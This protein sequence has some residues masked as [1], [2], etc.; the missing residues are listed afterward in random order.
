[1]GSGNGRLPSIVLVTGGLD[2][3]GA[4]RVLSDM[5]NYWA[6][7]SWRTTLVTWSGPELRDFYVLHSGVHRVWLHAQARGAFGLG[8]IHASISRIL[9]LRRLLKASRPDAVLSFIDVSN[10]HTILAAVGLGV[11]IVVS[12]RTSPGVN[13]TV[14]QPWR[15]LR[16]ILYSWADVVVAQTRDAAD[17][18]EKNCRVTAVVIP[19]SIR[20]LP[21]TACERGPLIVAVGR[22]S[23]EKGFDLLLRAF[24]Q[25]SADFPQWRLAIVGDGPQR[26]SL[27]Q[28][29]LELDLAGQAE[30]IG[31]VRDVEAWMARAGLFVHPSR[32]E[33]FP[34]AVLEA[35]ALGTPVVCADCP[36]GPSDLIDDGV[37]GRLVPV[38]DVDTLARV[39]AE[40]MARSVLR[41]RLGREAARVRIQ[42]DVG[43]IMKT[44]EACLLPNISRQS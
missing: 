40:L 4:Q 16:R 32:R 10:I 13:L 33:G 21:G 7:R 36:S 43:S 44:W 41:D 8:R 9:K 38:D 28:L 29:S 1:M 18:L 35:M 15:A 11:R 12:E 30:M 31:E 5:A 6:A 34:N 24:A 25:I 39:M 27:E 19:N 37:N 2:C 14:T 17:W 23:S 42:Y 22:L 20:A 3:G 26:Q